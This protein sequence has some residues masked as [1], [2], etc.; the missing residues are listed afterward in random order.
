MHPTDN[1]A[2]VEGLLYTLMEIPAVRSPVCSPSS[3]RAWNVTPPKLWLLI[4]GAQVATI[5]WPSP[6]SERFC[7]HHAC[8]RHHE[9]RAQRE[10]HCLS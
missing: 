10:S 3:D 7:A 8:R 4:K 9:K 6:L 5:G 2:P 1:T